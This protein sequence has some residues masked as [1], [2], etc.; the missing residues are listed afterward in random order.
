[1]ASSDSA[2]PP[3]EGHFESRAAFVQSVRQCVVAFSE[4]GANE[5]WICDADFAD[6]PLNEIDVIEQLTRWCRPSRTFNVLASDYGVLE[7]RCPRWVE[8]RRMWSHLVRCRAPEESRAMSLPTL[9]VAPGV[10]TLRL[11][12]R[13]L[14][15]G[16]V[17]LD[18]GAARRGLETL[19]ALLQRSVDSFPAH[20]LGL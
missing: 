1:M 15:R 2:Q 7:R 18:A 6:W 14:Y 9:L 3:L 16:D 8:W 19:D 11:F 5:V 10:A 20:T 4:Q 17:S 13:R 12:D